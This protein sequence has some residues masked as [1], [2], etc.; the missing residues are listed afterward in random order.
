MQLKKYLIIFSVLLAG[1]GGLPPKPSINLCQLDI[2]DGYGICNKTASIN[3]LAQLEAIVKAP[4]VSAS[5]HIPIAEMDKYEAVSQADWQAIQNY[6]NALVAAV[7][8]T[9]N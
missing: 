5:T 4:R 1:C 3:T 9:C 6:I 2:P 8:K 7:Q